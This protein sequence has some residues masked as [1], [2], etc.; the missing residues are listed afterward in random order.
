MLFNYLWLSGEYV[1]YKFPR[2]HLSVVTCCRCNLCKAIE[3]RENLPPN[4]RYRCRAPSARQSPG[5]F[6]GPPCVRWLTIRS[7]ASRSRRWDCRAGNSIAFGKS[8]QKFH[9]SCVG[10]QK[11]VN[12]TSHSVGQDDKYYQCGVRARL[13]KPCVCLVTAN[14][15]IGSDG[16]RPDL[17]IKLIYTSS[18]C[19]SAT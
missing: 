14:E 3:T 8:H 13:R 18:G 15:V 1:S 11:A 9:L 2:P 17:L 5:R 16:A 12:L 7:A 4:C 19:P 10:Q 6:A